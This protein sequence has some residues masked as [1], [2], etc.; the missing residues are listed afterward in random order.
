MCLQDRHYNDSITKMGH[1]FIADWLFMQ[2]QAFNVIDCDILWRSKF[3]V[4]HNNQLLK[5][6]CIYSN[7]HFLNELLDN[8]SHTESTRID[9]QTILCLV[10][11]SKIKSLEKTKLIL[12]RYQDLVLKQSDNGIS[13]IHHAVLNR[14]QRL[15]TELLSSKEIDINAVTKQK[16]TALHIAY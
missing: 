6:A 1:S 12:T 3:E 16:C 13:P 10:C 9:G 8:L 14:D 15:L 7:E 2:W 11:K 4:K 5:N